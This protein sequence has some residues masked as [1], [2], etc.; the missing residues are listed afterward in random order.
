MGKIRR[1][2]FVFLTWIG[3][4][5]PYHV[6]V[7]KIDSVEFNNHKAEF[8]VAA[9]GRSF[10]FPFAKLRLG[11]SSNNA[12][13]QVFVDEEL[14]REAFTYRLESGAEDSI[15][16]DSVLELNRDPDYFSD[17]IMYKLTVEA[18]KAIQ[19]SGLGKRQIARQMGTSPAQLYRLLD[20]NN[21]N[22]SLGQL[23]FLLHLANKHVELRISDKTVID[24][25]CS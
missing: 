18:L 8:E 25:E 12:I 21:R 19:Q 13:S 9:D 11:P 22:K 5:S 4:H 10:T 6:H 15:H 17:L 14:D 2:G 3:D 16:I 24:T 7:M 20:T 23:L 1:G